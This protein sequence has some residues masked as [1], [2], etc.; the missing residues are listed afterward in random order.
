MAFHSPQLVGFLSRFN[1]SRYSLSYLSSSFSLFP[2]LT[3]NVQSNALNDERLLNQNKELSNFD[4]HR[5]MNELADLLGI[6]SNTSAQNSYKESNVEKQTESKGVDGFLLPEERLRGVFLQKLKGKTAIEAALTSV[7]ADL[8]LDIVGK[9]VNQGNLGGEAIV[10]FF[11]WAIK[12]PN[13]RKDIW[14][15]NM[16]IKAL[17]RRKY[18]DFMGEI[19]HDMVKEGIDLD[20]ETLSIVLDSFVRAGHVYKAVQ[21]FGNL[22]DFGVKR[23]TEP[24]NVLLR[25]LCQRLHVGAA[26]SFFNSM[27]GKILF[28]GMTYNIIVGGWS[29]LGQ[30]VEIERVLKEMVAEGFSPD[31]LTFS[32]LIEGLGR[33]GRIND[34]I[35]VFDTMKEKGCGPDTN[36]YNAMISNYIS[37]GDFD[38]SMKYYKSMSILNCDPNMDTYIR[39]ISGLLKARKVADALEVFE[40]MLDRGIVPST[41]T[42]TSFIEP[43]CSYGPPHAAMMIYKKARKV[44]CKLSLTAYKL[45]LRRLSGFGKCG[46]L[47]DSWYEMQ[48]SGYSSD[49]E[50]YEYVIT[51]LC[52]V[53]QL[54][55]AVLVMEESLRRGF[56][57]SRLVYSKLSNKLLASNKLE[58]AYK[59]FLKIK[60][61]RRN[62]NARRL[63]RSNGWH[64]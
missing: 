16:I 1:R 29:K 25:C 18:F 24:L 45:L 42:V 9:V 17:G 41:G 22:Q 53:G 48:E 59:L 26:N 31:S 46:M 54:E 28:N 4:E 14:S 21:M 30:I 12:Q 39:L 61:A 40:E 55:N 2:F 20:L 52:T 10:M 49:R 43:L 38:E 62:A 64:F 44:G 50:V 56:C 47:L 36:S 19:L 57:P 58:T 35:E 3:I 63:W 32:Y 27:R 7:N 34:A 37:V 5:V 8:S 13:I 15:Y 23:D 6:S 51:G 33:A 60:V 11:K